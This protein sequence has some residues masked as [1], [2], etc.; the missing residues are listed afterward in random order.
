MNIPHPLQGNTILD[1][2]ETSNVVAVVDFYSMQVGWD[3]TTR[4]LAV[5]NDEEKKKEETMAN[6]PYVKAVYGM[7]DDNVFKQIIRD[8]REVL[9]G[10][11]AHK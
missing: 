10:G 11:T 7:D 1:M 3:D 8:H 4:F 2:G 6:D 5:L 9:M